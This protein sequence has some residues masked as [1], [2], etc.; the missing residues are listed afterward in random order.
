MRQFVGYLPGLKKSFAVTFVARADSVDL[1]VVR[2]DG[3]ARSVAPLRFRAQLPAPG[4]EVFVLGYPLGIHALL[5]RAETSTLDAMRRSLSLDFWTAAARLASTGEIAP[6][7]PAGLSA[8]R[9]RGR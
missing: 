6:I 8:S 1:A 7:A 3:A 5:A 2:G 9:A 4:E